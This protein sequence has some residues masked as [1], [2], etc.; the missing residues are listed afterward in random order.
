MDKL[1]PLPAQRP[2]RRWGRGGSC[3]CGVGTLP[4]DVA[5]AA[6]REGDAQ[7][8]LDLS[9]LQ[10]CPGPVHHGWRTEGPQ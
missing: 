6:D 8:G 1:S 4:V 7:P 2:R 3:G 10:L 9:L 5:G